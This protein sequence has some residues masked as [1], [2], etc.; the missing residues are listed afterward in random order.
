MIEQ[1][2]GEYPIHVICAVIGYSRS[3]Y[4]YQLDGPKKAA[5]STL[6]TAIA[7]VAGRY[8]TYG[9]RR[10]TKQL[11]REGWTMNHKRVTRLM[12]EM[13]LLAKKR[14]RR[15][16]TTNSVHG[17]KRY[18]N[19]VKQLVV[20]RPEQ[21]WVADITYIRLKEEFVYLAVL[22]DVF[23]RSIR[24][25]HL[26]RTME[27]RLTITALEKAF[28]H[29]IPEIHHSDQGVQY[30]ANDYVKLLEDNEIA[31][32]MAGVGKAYENGYAE[33]LMRT[34]KEEEVDLSEYRNFNEVYERIEAFLEEVYM[35]KRIH[36]SLRYLTPSEFEAQWRNEQSVV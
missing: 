9:Y 12:R 18:P 1:L 16:R 8:P 32:S 31:I 27:K 33:R 7:D 2:K 11:Q 36:S 26:D 30:A 4:Y 35:Q 23:T 6:K 34:I 20:E 24:G 28:E 22:M 13:G 5:E 29:Y 17:Y 14:V 19:L 3:R 21:V 25:W 10:I 15:K